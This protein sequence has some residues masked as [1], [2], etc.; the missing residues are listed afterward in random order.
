MKRVW[1][2][3]LIANCL[4]GRACLA[5]P[6]PSKWQEPAK[7][8]ADQVAGI[9]GP[10]QAQFTIRN[11]SSI[12]SGEIPTIRLLLE[13]D[14]KAHGVLTSGAESANAI[15][16]T[17]SENT[18]ERLW[19]AE[20]IEGNQRQVAMVRVELESVRQTQSEGGL[21]LRKQAILATKDWVLAALEMSDGLVVVEP[22]EIVIY[23]QNA[24]GW[25]E[26]KRVAIGQRKSLNRDPR[27]AIV[28]SHDGEGFE[29]FVAGMVCDGSLALGAATSEWVVRCRE[30]D[31]PWPLYEPPSLRS[32]TAQ[33]GENPTVT[34]L[35]AFF[36]P[37]RNY[38]SGL[39]SPS[40]GTDLPQFYSAAVVPRPYASGSRAALL[41]N[42][43][44]GRVQLTEA[45]T[46]KPV[47]GARDWG[48]DFA[49][50]NT[51]CGS[52]T[53]IVASASGEA[54]ADSLRAYDLPAQ[55]AIPASAPLPLD[56]TAMALW[57][58]PDGKSLLAVVRKPGVQGA[59][60]QY[61]VDRVTS[62][63]N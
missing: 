7:A 1:L 46:L 43:I 47:S 54:L 51:A 56:G 33:Q 61:E 30:G 9:L 49:I 22:E 27:G 34:Q 38:F 17:L 14:L 44:D 26:Q 8:L 55:E 37:T 29:A 12:P 35:K 60:D 28:P 23:G 24:E 41:V 50:L 16:V 19:V 36:N 3:V 42:G 53:Q 5:A 25:R 13:E 58:A 63:C 45:G 52:G 6:A 4:V 57:T 11:A 10:G 15:R 59:A 32:S 62:S 48:S 31:D 2:A 39:V 18:R 20:V 40:L 21:T